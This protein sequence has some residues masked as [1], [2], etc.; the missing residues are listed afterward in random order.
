MNNDCD[1]T[2]TNY[3][4]LCGI[5]GVLCSATVVKQCKICIVQ[6]IQQENGNY[7]IECQ[8]TIIPH[9]KRLQM[10]PLGHMTFIIAFTADFSVDHV[11]QIH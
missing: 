9:K 8:S 10:V 7:Q 3:V 6:T 4:L 2:S 5:T 1:C 11:F